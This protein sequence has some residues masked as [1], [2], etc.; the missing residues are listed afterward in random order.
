MIG[1]YTFNSVLNVDESNNR[2]VYKHALS[3]ESCAIEIPPGNFEI[4]ALAKYIQQQ[5]IEEEASNNHEVDEIFSLRV[6]NTTLRCEMK[7]MH[8]VNFTVSN[9]PAR[10]LGFT[11]AI[12]K[13]NQQHQSYLSMEILKHRIVQVECNIVSDAYSHT[14]IN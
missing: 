1:F 6:N 5:V 13:R 9:T 3:G 4:D 10:I 12:Y 11:P 7:C 14:A 8:D 2:F